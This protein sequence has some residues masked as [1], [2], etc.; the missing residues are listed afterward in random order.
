V[1]VRN[2]VV[3]LCRAASSNRSAEPP[4]I[5]WAAA[6]QK[7]SLFI[8]PEDLTTIHNSYASPPIGD[9]RRYADLVFEGGGVKGI[10]FVG[11][12]R[13]LDDAQISVRKVA[14]TSAGSLS[15]SAVAAGLSIDDLE[16]LLG[17]VD[18]ND[19]FLS[20]PTGRIYRRWPF[21]WGPGNDL[22]HPIKMAIFLKLNRQLGQYNMDK[23]EE[24]WDE[25]LGKLTFGKLDECKESATAKPWQDQRDLKIIVSDITSHEMVLL[26]DDLTRKYGLQSSNFS[27]AKAVRLSSSIPL[28]FAPGHLPC[29][30]GKVPE[31]TIV[32]GG[33]LSNFPL[34]VYDTKGGQLPECPT[35]GMLLDDE[36]GGEEP[37]KDILQVATSLLGTLLAN[38]R[39]KR[40]GFS[41]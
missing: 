13:C 37:I 14:G 1:F 4:G 25:S 33:V 16:R 24:W 27:V 30:H 23:F 21:K 5:N 29:A 26:P 38:T 39:D 6:R 11:A 22:D 15:A 40:C 32:D 10:A 19:K 17:N 8:S 20:T 18:F 28:F 2:R 3:T 7:H 41:C 9:S 12:L 34:W 31:H 36:V 35:L